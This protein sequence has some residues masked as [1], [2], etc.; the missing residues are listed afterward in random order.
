MTIISIHA[1]TEE[2]D[3]ND[4]EEFYSTLEGVC[5]TLPQYDHWMIM[6]DFN[7][8]IGK[9]DYQKQVAGTHTLHD[10]SNDNGKMLGHFAARN[11][12]LIKS[13]WFPHKNIHKGTWKIPG[14]GETN[15]ID[16]V[17]SSARHASSVIDVRSYRGPNCDSDH[18]LVKAVVRERLAKIQNLKA[19]KKKLWNTDRFKE[20]PVRDD[21]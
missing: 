13:T 20:T 11:K 10:A 12:M 6:G 7:A 1:P 9:E 14:T 4:K 16:H 18:Y 8:K 2:Q 21:Y 17:L 5:N 3:E 15:Q 19:T